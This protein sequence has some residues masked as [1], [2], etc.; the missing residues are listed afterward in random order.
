MNIRPALLPAL[1]AVLLTSGCLSYIPPGAK[2]DLQ[3][4]ATPDIQAG[5]AAKATAPFPATIAAVHVQAPDYSNYYIRNNGGIYG[6]GKYSIVTVHEA[7]TQA[8]FDRIQAL[9]QVAG[10]ITLNR[11]LLPARLRDDRDFRAAAARLRADLVLVYTFDTSFF[12]HDAAKPFTVITLGLSPTRKITAVTTV[13]ALL[14]DTRTG[15]IYSAYEDTERKQTLSTS[16]GSRDTADE[17]RQDT[18]RRAFAKLVDDF[19]TSW[20][21]LLRQYG[22]AAATSTA[23]KPS[24][25]RPPKMASL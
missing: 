25:A 16:W 3:A 15:Y 13:S 1:F 4:F 11:M 21:R 24:V 19:A 14:M 12:D 5:F 9:P 7:E 18:E 22:N 6:T 17:A 10:L 2:A 8:E 20:P 23:P